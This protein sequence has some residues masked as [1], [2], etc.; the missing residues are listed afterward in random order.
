MATGSPLRLYRPPVAVG[1]PVVG[2]MGAV[3]GASLGVL[4]SLRAGTNREAQDGIS[5]ALM[6]FTIPIAAVRAG[7]QALDVPVADVLLA[8]NGWLLDLV[9]IAALGVVSFVAVRIARARFVRT[10]LLLD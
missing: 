4:I 1:G 6:A 9:L 7:L 10:R 2:L 5:L 8:I 3:A